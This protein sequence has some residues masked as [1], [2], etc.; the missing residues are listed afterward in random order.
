MVSSSPATTR[1]KGRSTTT[2]HWSRRDA[3]FLKVYADDRIY[4][5]R[6]RTRADKAYAFTVKLKP[7]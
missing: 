3:V 5:T 1:T 2:G 4:K 6:A 7:D